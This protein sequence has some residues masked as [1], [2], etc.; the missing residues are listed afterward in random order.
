M[1]YIN[2]ITSKGQI[3]LPKEYRERLGLDKLGRAQLSMNERGEIVVTRP[4]TLAETR[5][6]LA[7]PGGADDISEREM[8]IGSELARKYG[9]R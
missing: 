1:S 9:V 6:L 8:M 5:A 3:T 4:R 2:S 7:K